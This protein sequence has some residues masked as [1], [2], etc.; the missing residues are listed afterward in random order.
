MNI[1]W[2]KRKKLF[3]LWEKCVCLWTFC[4]Y[5]WKQNVLY[6]LETFNY[7]WLWLNVLDSE[8]GHILYIYIYIYITLYVLY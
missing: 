8:T 6:S 3:I 4:L 1:C 5:V 7:I 2:I